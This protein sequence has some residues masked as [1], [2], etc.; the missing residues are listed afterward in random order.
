[1]NTIKNNKL[2]QICIKLNKNMYYSK[3]YK[4]NKVLFKNNPNNKDKPTQYKP[5]NTENGIY[6]IF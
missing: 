5:M 3:N 1:M 2:K 6:L 4:E